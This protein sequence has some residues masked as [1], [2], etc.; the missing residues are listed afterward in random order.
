MCNE[1]VEMCCVFEECKLIDCV[2]GMIMKVKG[3]GE[4]EVYVFLCKVV[5][6]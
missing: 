4:E 6:D 1:L 5:M 2:K 3:V